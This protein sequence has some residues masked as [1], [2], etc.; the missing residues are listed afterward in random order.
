MKKYIYSSQ[1]VAFAMTTFIIIIINI[2]IGHRQDLLNQPASQPF[3]H[4]FLGP[5]NGVRGH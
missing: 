3:T 1:F 5:F 2:A 4:W